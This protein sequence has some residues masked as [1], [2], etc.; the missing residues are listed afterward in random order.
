MRI[1]LTDG[2]LNPR[3]PPAQLFLNN[4]YLHFYRIKRRTTTTSVELQHLAHQAPGAIPALPETPAQ[5]LISSIVATTASGTAWT[6]AAI[7]IGRGLA[8][9]SNLL[10]ARFLSA[11]DF[12]SVAF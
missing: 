6:I 12:G 1:A 2:A 5:A 8:F 10:L 4:D 9:G 3:S 7:A 11:S